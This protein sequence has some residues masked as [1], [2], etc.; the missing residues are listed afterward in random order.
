MSG[1]FAKDALPMVGHTPAIF[2]F[3]CGLLCPLPSTTGMRKEKRQVAQLQNFLHGAARSKGGLNFY[4]TKTCTI[5]EFVPHAGLC[6]QYEGLT[7]GS[8]HYFCALG[9][10]KVEDGECP[11]A[12]DKK[13]YYQRCDMD[14]SQYLNVLGAEW[15]SF[16]MLLWVMT[17]SLE[18]C[19]GNVQDVASEM[20]R[21]KAKADGT[22]G[23]MTQVNTMNAGR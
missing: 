3:L 21:R 4:K 18:F 2:V 20:I 8:L 10:A 23:N 16:S 13:T 1:F 15:D 12:G 5:K 14:V 19:Y 11:G 7:F 9:K 22:L 6:I 17:Y